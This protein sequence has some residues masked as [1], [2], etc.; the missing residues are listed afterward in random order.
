[1]TQ[2]F[3]SYSRKDIS[4]IDRL[5]ADLK[6]AGI[7]VWYDVSRIAGGARWRSEI[8][9]ALR[10]SQ[11]VIVVL[12]PDSIVSE[13]VEREFLFSSNLK[14]KI[15]PLMYRACELPLNYVDLNYIDVQGES[16]AQNFDELLKVLN[17]GSKTSTLPASNVANPPFK[18]KTLPIALMGGGAILTAVLLGSLLMKGLIAPAPTPT[19]MMVVTQGLTPPTLTSIPAS[20]TPTS[21]SIPTPSSDFWI[22]F[23]SNINGNR[24]IFLLNPVTGE[25]R[26]VITDRYHDKVGTWSPD[27]KFLAFE[28]SRTDP[29]YYQIYLYNSGQGITISLTESA[30]CSSFAPDWSPDGEK[31]IFYSY[32]INSQR[33]I[34][35]MNR[36]GSARKQLTTSSGEDQFPAF[37][38]DG[39]SITFTST[40]NGKYQIL[41][42][43]TDG[44]NQRVVAD[45]CSS[46]FSPDGNWLWFSTKCDDSDIKHIQIDGTSLSTIG[47]VFGHNPSLSPDGK[48]VA[49]QYNDDIWIMGVD[50]SNP[51]PLTSGSALDGAPSWWEP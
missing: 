3:I 19:E 5:A 12:S 2:V 6:T 22:T 26:G 41:L 43:N 40:R 45:G 42:M 33:D 17:V 34:Y 31:I 13:W 35:I 15:I 21:T 46:T 25:T 18:W 47:S 8:E 28:S 23:D 51:K 32:C 16:Y 48:L 11:Y 27:G 20:A 49:F 38:P 29:N 24:D 39:N 4:F 14:R 1:M 7:D 36:D 10:N 30:E 44:S 50:G 37:S 9:N